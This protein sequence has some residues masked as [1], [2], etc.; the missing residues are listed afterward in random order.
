MLTPKK[1]IKNMIVNIEKLFNFEGKLWVDVR[2]YVAK[3]HMKRKKDIRILHGDY[4]MDIPANKIWRTKKIITKQPIKS[5][6]YKDQEY[7]LWSYEWKPI[8]KVPKYIIQK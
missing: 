7:H 2:D 8:G 6:I 1:R 4:Y 5:I 3:D